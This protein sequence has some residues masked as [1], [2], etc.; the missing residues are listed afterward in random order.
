MKYGK[1]FGHSFNIVYKRAHRKQSVVGSVGSVGTTG[2]T[3]VAN[4]RALGILLGTEWQTQNE[5]F[6]CFG[7]KLFN[8]KRRRVRMRSVANTGLHS[9]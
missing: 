2:R 6:V 3:A 8:N 4:D 1:Q 9:N 7:P 5:F